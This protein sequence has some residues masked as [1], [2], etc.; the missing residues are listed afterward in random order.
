MGSLPMGENELKAILKNI[1][2]EMIN[3]FRGISLE[4]S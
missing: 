3:I 1:K 2:R 4:G